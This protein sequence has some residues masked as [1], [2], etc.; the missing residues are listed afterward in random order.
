RDP[1]FELAYWSWALTAAC[2]MWER[3]GRAPPPR[4]SEV[5]TGLA[6]AKVHEGSYAALA[7]PPYLV[8][9]DHPSMLAAFGVVPPTQVIDPEVMA[10]TFDDVMADWHWASTWGWDY[11]VAAM[12]AARLGRWNAAV[13]EVDA[14][15][16]VEA[17]LLDRPKNVYLVNGHNHQTDQLPVYLPGNGSLLMAVALMA[18]GW[19]GS[20]PTPGFGT[21]WSVA[22]EGLV[23]LP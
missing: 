8:R 10:R 4:W 12:T 1:T 15:D 5:A 3:L 20:G 19:D 18:G 14:V 13:D 6:H 11:P 21:G 7:T 2:G 16:A 23:R 17:L 22:H 9:D